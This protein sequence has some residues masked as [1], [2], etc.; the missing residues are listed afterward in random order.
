MLLDTGDGQL[1]T[2][3]L[4][5]DCVSG[6]GMVSRDLHLW[7]TVVV[8]RSELCSCISVIP[9]LRLAMEHGERCDVCHRACFVLHFLAIAFTPVLHNL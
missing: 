3:R 5:S 1:E 7:V 4:L 8:V 9:A 2:Q 6:P